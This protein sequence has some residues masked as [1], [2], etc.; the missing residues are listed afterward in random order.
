MNPATLPT[1]MS[2]GN[3]LARAALGAGWAILVVCTAATACA[4]LLVARLVTLPFR[5]P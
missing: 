4:C 1:R 2:P 3:K 5:K